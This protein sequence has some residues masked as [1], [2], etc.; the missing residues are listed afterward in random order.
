MGGLVAVTAS[1]ALGSRSHWEHLL[2]E[3]C[4][5]VFGP[6]PAEVLPLPGHSA[7]RL[8]CQEVSSS[9]LWGPPSAS[10]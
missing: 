1:C 2:N 4:G 9:A 6:H 5:P 3:F 7:N 10:G 8:C